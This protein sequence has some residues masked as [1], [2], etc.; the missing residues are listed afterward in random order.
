MRFRLV[1]TL[2]LGA[3][4]LGLALLSGCKTIL[5]P[6]VTD[7]ATETVFQPD[8]IIYVDAK[9]G[10][11]HFSGQRPH[12]AKRS[13]EAAVR[14]LR[15]D[16]HNVLIQLAPGQYN[17]DVAIVNRVAH[18]GRRVLVLGDPGWTPDAVAGPSVVIT[19]TK[20][21]ATE[22]NLESALIAV[23]SSGFTFSGV[24]FRD[25]AKSAVI[26]EDCTNFE[27]TRCRFANN[28]ETGLVA[29]QGS[30]VTLRHCLATG[31]QQNGVHGVNSTLTLKN[32]RAVGNS[33]SGLRADQSYVHIED[34]A[35][36]ENYFGLLLGAGSHA[37]GRGACRFS[38][39]RRDGASL[40]FSSF[41]CGGGFWGEASNNQDFGFRLD[42][43]SSLGFYIRGKESDLKHSGNGKGDVTVHTGS[44]V[45]Q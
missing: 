24:E 17:E 41:Y 15:D 1:S 30:D 16:K 42:M 21:G 18:P 32:S 39:N 19:G 26:L 27:F 2:C 40:V 11:N 25:C 9:W 4:L 22:P 5:M 6:P 20:T 38:D 31:N 13:L 28:K 7:P 14:A 23:K 37:V 3:V 8:R 12:K 45:L 10:Q 34:S 43:N 29:G 35:F 33:F 36:M 44:S